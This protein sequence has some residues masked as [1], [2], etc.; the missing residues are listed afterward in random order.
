[1]P[2]ALLAY[3]FWIVVLVE[4]AR[5]ALTGYESTGIVLGSYGLFAPFIIT[6]LSWVNAARRLRRLA[7]D[8]PGS[9]EGRETT[10]E[11]DGEKLPVT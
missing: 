2:A 11:K 6:G 7:G 3:S 4:T 1:M 9:C 8:G 5:P 10:S